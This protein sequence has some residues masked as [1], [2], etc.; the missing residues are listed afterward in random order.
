MAFVLCDYVCK[1]INFL[2]FYFAATVWK[3]KGPI[4]SLKQINNET[5]FNKTNFEIHLNL[6]F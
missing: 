4:P 2:N 6:R 5:T 1:C 3:L